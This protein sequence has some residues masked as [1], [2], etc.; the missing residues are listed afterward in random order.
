[1]QKTASPS[2][3]RTQRLAGREQH[4]AFFSLSLFS[5]LFSL[6]Y[7]LFS[8]FLFLPQSIHHRPPHHTFRRTLP[9]PN[10][11]LRHSLRDEHF[12]ARDRFDAAP[13]RDL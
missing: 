10:F 4:A 12:H 5:F 13:L 1:M 11:P 7:L 2:A 9:R 8:P 6:L 3:V